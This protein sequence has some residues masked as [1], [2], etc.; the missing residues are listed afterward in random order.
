V[1]VGVVRFAL[2][3]FTLATLATVTAYWDHRA[4]ARRAEAFRLGALMGGGV[5]L[6]LFGATTADTLAAIVAVC[7]F[8]GGSLPT[9]SPA[10]SPLA[11]DLHAGRQVEDHELQ[12][13]LL[14]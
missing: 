14:R 8:S 12:R 2:A 3:A 6:V 4:W 5:A 9:T 1:T 13:L 10:P 7:A 11:D